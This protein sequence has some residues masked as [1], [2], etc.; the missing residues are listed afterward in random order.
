[1]ARAPRPARGRPLVTGLLCA[2]LLGSAGGCSDPVE[3]PA[4]QPA[5]TPQSASPSTPDASPTP[6]EEEP[7]TPPPLSPQQQ[8]E[9]DRRLIAATWDNDVRRA[10][11]LIARGADV[12]AQDETQ[13]SAYL[14]TTSEG[15]LRLL[16]LTLR[17]GA[18]VD[19]KD[20]FNGT[21]LIRAAD[22]GHWDVAGRLIVA[23]VEIDHVN[24][25]GWTALHEAIIL[26]DG[27]ER[28]VDTVRVLVAA[29][30]DVEL[31][32]ERDG[33]APLDHASSRGY[34]AISG[35]LVRAIEADADPGP[36]RVAAG[37]DLLAAATTGDADAAVLALREGARLET[38]DDE[39][40]TPL[41][42]ASAGA[43]LD[44]V[45]LLG[46]LGAEPAPADR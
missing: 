6:T 30:A 25:L 24:N 44:V 23:G 10:R 5:P 42:L 14:V 11:Q 43:H 12:N 28:Y 45:R 35:L 9:A 34:D 33:I 32:S 19:A 39:G 29:G 16:E 4:A 46:A 38:R 15:Y 36:G 13:Q 2:A 41:E 37:D 8:A 31:R 7:V 3:R 18:D 27:S 26:G 22:R 17:N 1:M 21:G 20:S 40:R